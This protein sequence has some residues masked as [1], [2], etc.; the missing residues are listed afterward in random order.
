MD[1]VAAFYDG[2]AGDYHCVYSDWEL[3]IGRQAAALGRVICEHLGEGRHR[4]LDCTCGIGTQ[5][6]GLAQLG[7]GVVGVDLS[8]ISIARARIEADRRGLAIQFHVADLRTLNLGGQHDFDVV[9][10]A[11]NALP[12]LLQDAQLEQAVARMVAHLRGG[13]MFIATIRDYDA[14]L[15]D[16]P[17]STSPVL[18]GEAGNRRATFQLWHWADD[19]RTYRL[20]QFV[21]Q[22]TGAAWT[23][24][25]HTTGYRALRRAELSLVLGAA[26]L[27][28]SRWL[29][30]GQT[31]FFQPMLTAIRGA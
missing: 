9:L 10:S 2:L 5:S 19:R 17:R 1:E 13:G 11:D 12:H 28:I 15:E 24:Q 20:E 31:G 14:I 21:L 29:L 4:I 22:Q 8:P 16:P 3:S 30:P 23:V 7:F 6:L 18:T 27:P 26:G 25:I